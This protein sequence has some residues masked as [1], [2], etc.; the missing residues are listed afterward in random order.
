MKDGGW[1][2]KPMGGELVVYKRRIL[3]LSVPMVSA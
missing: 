2:V 3:L 1:A